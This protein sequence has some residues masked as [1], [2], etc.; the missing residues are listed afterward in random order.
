MTLAAD[1]AAS[2][3]SVSGFKLAAGNKLG[4]RA[5]YEEGR[6]KVMVLDES[7]GAFNPVDVKIVAGKGIPLP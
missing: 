1:L 2:T 7:T 3:P 6:R 5:A 4:R